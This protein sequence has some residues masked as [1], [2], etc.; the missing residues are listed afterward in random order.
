VVRA[1]LAH[2]RAATALSDPRSVTPASPTRIILAAH[3]WMTPREAA[4][5][6]LAAIR[7]SSS[8]R[9]RASR[10]PARRPAFHVDLDFR[11]PGE[12]DRAIGSPAT[13]PS[14]GAGSALTDEQAIADLE[15]AVELDPLAVVPWSD[16]SESS[17]GPIRRIGARRPTGHRDCTDLPARG[18]ASS[19]WSARAEI[20]RRRG[21]A[22]R[23]VE[24]DD[25]AGG[26]RNWRSPRGGGPA[27]RGAR[28]V[29]LSDPF[30]S[31]AESAR[32][33]ALPRA[34]DKRSRSGTSA[35]LTWSVRA[36]SRRTSPHCEANRVSRP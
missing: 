2:F 26:S 11:W 36:T 23:G 25:S 19:G 28:C 34:P 20:P 1:A 6:A 21:G 16:L 8:I 7:R 4:P 14:T 9:R 3:N 33:T 32:Q 13:T 22:R 10:T 15:R 5:I 18:A 35:W 31:P 27:R 30:E 29:P 24:R 17:A 12:H